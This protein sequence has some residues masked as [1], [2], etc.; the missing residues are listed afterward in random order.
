MFQL[1]KIGSF[2]SFLCLGPHP[3]LGH[4]R[5]TGRSLASDEDDGK[6]EARD[7]SWIRV[8]QSLIREE[9]GFRGLCKG[10]QGAM[11]GAELAEKVGAGAAADFPGAS[12]PGAGLPGKVSMGRPAP[13][14]A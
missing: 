1:S 14:A 4:F 5:G 10:A 8:R 13:I 6:P 7:F 3:W 12:P 9:K 11:P 2:T